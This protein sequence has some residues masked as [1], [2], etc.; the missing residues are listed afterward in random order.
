MTMLV[1]VLVKIDS[2]VRVSTVEK[3]RL[4]N[5]PSIALQV[6][7]KEEALLIVIVFKNESG[8]E[9]MQGRQVLRPINNAAHFHKLQTTA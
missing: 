7:E 9:E 8:R 4:A 2:I 5:G 1:D 6:L 3:A